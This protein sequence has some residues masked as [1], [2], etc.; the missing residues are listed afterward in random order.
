MSKRPATSPFTG[1]EKRVEPSSPER[2]KSKETASPDAVAA[3]V[4]ELTRKLD[5]EL[6]LSQS[7]SAEVRRNSSSLS[8]AQVAIGETRAEAYRRKR[9]LAKSLYVT[10]KPQGGF[11]DEILIKVNTINGNPFRGTFTSDEI[12]K[13]IFV[14]ILGFEKDLLH[15]YK[16]EWRNGQLTIY[17]KMKQQSNIDDLWECENFTFTREIKRGAEVMHDKIECNIMGIRRRPGM[18]NEWEEQEET[19]IRWLKIEGAEYRL[20]KKEIVD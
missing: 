11:K 19:G 9:E 6:A 10:P 16:T 7:T 12:W 8:Y 3:R 18:L 1:R 5:R 15:G 17:L 13:G 2:E 14:S 20:E 4:G